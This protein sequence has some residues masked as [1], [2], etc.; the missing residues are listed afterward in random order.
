MQRT[1]IKP[2]QIYA[3]GTRSGHQFPALV[4]HRG[5]WTF[6]PYGEAVLSPADTGAKA[7]RK[8]V[9]G[10]YTSGPG[11][12]VDTGVLIVRAMA[13]ATAPEKVL[14]RLQEW[15]HRTAGM[16]LDTAEHA[17]TLKDV[18]NAE[19]LQLGVAIPRNILADW[20]SHA[21]RSD[22]EARLRRERLQALHQDK[23]E[24]EAKM[25]LIRTRVRGLGVDPAMVVGRARLDS[26]Y[27]ISAPAHVTLGLDDLLDLLDSAHHEREAG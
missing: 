3:A 25:D 16:E 27:T 18:L 6:D 13:T 20:D 24:R 23:Q 22:D 10:R 1:R 19:D 9:P 7:G 4:A 15:S 14:P 17:T 11:H 2:H 8:R 26:Q 21:Q 5:L 12:H